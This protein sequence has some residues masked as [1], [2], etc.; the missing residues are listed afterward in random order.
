MQRAEAPAPRA[1]ARAPAALAWRGVRIPLGITSPHRRSAIMAGVLV[2]TSLAAALKAG[3][4][5]VDRNDD[6]YTVATNTAQ[7]Q[8]MA[9]VRVRS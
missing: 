1:V 2:F 7:G 3:F 6:G 8:Q 5:V 9:L 4:R